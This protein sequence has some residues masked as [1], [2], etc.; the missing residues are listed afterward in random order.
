MSICD[1]SFLSTHC[2]ISSYFSVTL[3]YDQLA[4]LV[5][6]KLQVTCVLNTLQVY[7]W[8]STTVIPIIYELNQFFPKFRE[9]YY[10]G[11][12]IQSI[13]EDCNAASSEQ[14]SIKMQDR[15]STIYPAQWE[16]S[17]C[18]WDCARE[19]EYSA[20][21]LCTIS[22]CVRL[23]MNHLRGTVIKITQSEV[24]DISPHWT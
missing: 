10:T 8:P 12:L 3:L 24:P 16:R 21:V 17:R 7:P 14:Q 19:S 18:L 11:T 5:H 20:L 9:Q 6:E 4:T 23:K 13:R 1:P 15:V 22:S 2:I